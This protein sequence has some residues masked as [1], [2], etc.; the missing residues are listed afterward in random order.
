MLRVRQILESLLQFVTYIPDVK[1]N[2]FGLV[3]VGQ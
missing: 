3:V 1:K 2:V